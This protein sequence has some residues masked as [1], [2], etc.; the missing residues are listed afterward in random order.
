MQKNSLYNTVKWQRVREKVYERDHGLCQLCAKPGIDTHHLR[1]DQGFFNED[2]LIL[3]CRR[4]HNIWQGVAPTHIDDQNDIKSLLNRIA[5]I[6]RALNGLVC[7]YDFSGGG[8]KWIPHPK[9][10]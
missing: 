4:C 9:M 6:S 2:I 3:V 5:E 10:L 7:V 8:C 1:Y